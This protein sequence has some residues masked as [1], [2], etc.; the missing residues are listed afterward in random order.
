MSR[1]SHLLENNISNNYY[2]YYL[3]FSYE[4]AEGGANDFDSLHTDLYKAIEKLYDII[5]KNKDTHVHILDLEKKTIITFKDIGTSLDDV[6]IH[7]YRN[8]KKV[9]ITTIMRK[10]RLSYKKSKEIVDKIKQKYPK[11]ETPS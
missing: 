8:A 10:Y 5:K 3:L 6:I 9:S 7:E 4:K 1:L 2:S 11:I